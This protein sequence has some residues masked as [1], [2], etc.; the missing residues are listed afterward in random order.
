MFLKNTHKSA[1]FSSS[2]QI[3]NFLPESMLGF[4]DPKGSGP[5]PRARRHA[6]WVDLP[7]SEHGAANL[8]SFQGRC[9]P[10]PG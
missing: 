8:A 9:P 2:V 5:L 10:S 7:A 3:A 1:T 4:I 6:H